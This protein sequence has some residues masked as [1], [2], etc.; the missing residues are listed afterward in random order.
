MGRVTAGSRALP[1]VCPLT[2]ITCLHLL[3]F[4]FLKSVSTGCFITSPKL[5]FLQSSKPPSLKGHGQKENAETVLCLLTECLVGHVSRGNQADF[6]E[7]QVGPKEGDDEV[8]PELSGWWHKA[9]ATGTES[10]GG[11]EQNAR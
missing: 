8:S 6:Q 11:T 1:K 7:S 10:R 9:T 3:D 5:P 4:A 2:G